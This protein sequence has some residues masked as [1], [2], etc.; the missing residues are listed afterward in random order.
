MND[1]CYDNHDFDDMIEEFDGRSLVVSNS[2]PRS[3]LGTS[4][5]SAATDYSSCVINQ[6]PIL[7]QTNVIFFLVEKI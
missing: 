4:F 3:N 6:L 1:T 7:D 5:G 2:G